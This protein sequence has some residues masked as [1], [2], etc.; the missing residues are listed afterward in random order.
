MA[1]LY[2]CSFL[3]AIISD[4]NYQCPPDGIETTDGPVIPTEPLDTTTPD[5]GTTTPDLV[6]TMTQKAG[7]TTTDPVETTTRE[8]ATTTTA[9]PESQPG[10]GGSCGGFQE[11]LSCG[12]DEECCCGDCFDAIVCEC[13]G[14]QWACF[15][16]DACLEAPCAEETTTPD[17]TTTPEGGD[18]EDFDNIVDAKVIQK[19]QLSNGT[20]VESR[21]NTGN[22][23]ID[24]GESGSSYTLEYNFTL[25]EAGIVSLSTVS[26][27]IQQVTCFSE[28]DEQGNVTNSYVD[29]QLLSGLEFGSPQDLFPVGF[30]LVVNSDTFGPC[31]LRESSTETGSFWGP[32]GFLLIE[33]L[34]LLTDES[35]DI[36][37][38]NGK[39]KDYFSMFDRARFSGQKIVESSSRRDLALDVGISVQTEKN[40]GPFNQKLTINGNVRVDVDN[41]EIDYGFFDGLIIAMETIGGYRYDLGYA[42]SYELPGG[43]VFR[44]REE[45][46]WIAQRL[47][48]AIEIPAR[49][50]RLIDD[51]LDEFFEGYD[52][53]P[54]RFGLFFEV[55]VVTGPFEAKAKLS[56]DARIRCNKP[57]VFG[58][59]MRY[60]RRFLG[61]FPGQWT[62][63]S[64][65]LDTSESTCNVVMPS[66]GPVPIAADFFFSAFA[67]IE[68]QLRLNLFSLAYLAFKQPVGI[69]GKTTIRATGFQPYSKPGGPDEIFPL[70]N[71]VCENKHLIRLALTAGTG[72]AKL[73]A[74]VDVGN[75]V[76]NYEILS[77]L[78]FSFFYAVANFCL[79]DISCSERGCPAG[80]KC[81][82]EGADEICIDEDSCCAEDRCG[83]GGNCCPGEQNCCV[84][85]CVNSECNSPAPPSSPRSPSAGDPT[86]QP[87]RS[88]SGGGGGGGPPAVRYVHGLIWNTD[89]RH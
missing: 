21:S 16:T 64:L 60:Q 65:D 3:V 13:S 42:F 68:P 24:A 25:R 58:Y 41:F 46:P 50:R 76:F 36:V 29:I 28:V 69:T 67:G 84:G 81:C 22:L 87:N 9:C 4:P 66:L 77:P 70:V 32:D 79:I 55:P 35:G 33:A 72:Q 5:A 52:L 8:A 10:P 82:G 18:P 53:P 49:A 62:L 83:F 47:P 23:T 73:V 7:A 26:D 48:W 40:N 27:L 61:L 12:Y 75:V 6:E 19:A 86:P 2:T 89:C 30:L 39:S 14:T 31:L 44:P 80:Q 71:D 78:Q 11:F 57:N 51:L 1:I 37:R 54:L 85:V 63:E 15:S 88:P 20:D 74:K 59:K 43:K 34:V 45:Y 38:V 56:W 17:A